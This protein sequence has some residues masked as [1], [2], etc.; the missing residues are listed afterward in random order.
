MKIELTFSD[1]IQ[2]VKRICK[3]QGVDCA[4]LLGVS[5][6]TL[7]NW[8]NGRGYP[9]PMN[10][11]I[12]TELTEGFI[13]ADDITASRALE[14]APFQ[15]IDKEAIAQVRANVRAGLLVNGTPIQQKAD[16]LR[17]W[18]ASTGIPLHTH[19][20]VTRMGAYKWLEGRSRPHRSQHEQIIQNCGGLLTLEELAKDS[21]NAK[22]II[23]GK[24]GRPRKDG[25]SKTV[26]PV[27]TIRI[28]QNIVIPDLSI[29]DLFS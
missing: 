24:R 21:L 27:A 17:A 29:D 20:G 19:W 15:E 1:K 18:A 2:V 28:P 8:I 22:P 10:M 26:N 11:K 5:P 13:V 14:C 25:S 4:T 3:R 12:I 6:L 16:A 23:V 9:T 7:G